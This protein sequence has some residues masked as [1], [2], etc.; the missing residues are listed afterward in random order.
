MNYLPMEQYSK[1]WIFRHRDLPVPAEALE[2]IRPLTEQRAEQ[3]WAEH[4]SRGCSHPEHFSAEDWAG[5]DSSWAEGDYWQSAWDSN[6]PDLP[7]LLAEYL[8]DWDDNTRVFFCYHSDHIIE[9]SWGVW[10]RYW[11]NFLFFDNGPLLIGRKRKKVVQFFDNGNYRI[12][13][14]N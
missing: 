14:R 5:K 6:K 13:E 3:I 11:K 9:T 10:R 12:G 1:A 7:G 4:I 2:Q 8:Q